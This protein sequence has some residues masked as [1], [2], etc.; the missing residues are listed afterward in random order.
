MALELWFVK[1]IYFINLYLLRQLCLRRCM[2]VGV[3][4]D[5][6]M[7]NLHKLETRRGMYNDNA[8]RLNRKLFQH[9]YLK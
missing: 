2:G 6:C 3:G 9:S 5:V 8:R 7:R 4:V 1:I